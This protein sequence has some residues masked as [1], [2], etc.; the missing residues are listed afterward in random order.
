MTQKNQ[1][2]LTKREIR[3]LARKMEELVT[4]PPPEVVERMR[5]NLEEKRRLQA[6]RIPGMR[7]YREGAQWSA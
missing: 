2:P 4:N 3:E 7:M 1:N 6:H 5:K